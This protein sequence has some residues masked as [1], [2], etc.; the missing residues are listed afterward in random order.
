MSPSTI[1]SGITVVDVQCCYEKVKTLKTRQMRH[2]IVPTI[3]DV[4]QQPSC[5]LA[6]ACGSTKT[7]FYFGI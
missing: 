4:V 2:L 3:F 1:A 6:H 7:S 5:L